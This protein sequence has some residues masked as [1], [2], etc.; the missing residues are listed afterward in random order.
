M[1]ARRSTF[2]RGLVSALKLGAA[3]ALLGP[4]LALCTAAF[5]GTLAGGWWGAAMCLFVSTI[6]YALLLSS[7]P[8]HFGDRQSPDYKARVLNALR[9]GAWLGALTGLLMAGLG[10]IYG[11]NGEENS[12]R[13]M[14]RRT[15][16]VLTGQIPAFELPEDQRRLDVWCYIKM[17]GGLGVVVGAAR[18][19]VSM[20]WKRLPSRRDPP[21]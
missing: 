1:S 13:E 10:A 19:P 7:W 12:L 6:F 11:L 8:A 2:V 9:A 14:L 3:W 16:D 4:F 18:E 21:V 17:L 20:L 15:A 5:L